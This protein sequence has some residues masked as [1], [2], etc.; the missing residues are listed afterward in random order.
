VADGA[1]ELTFS[2]GAILF[3]DAGPDGDTLRVT[4]EAW[5]DPFAEPLSSINVEYVRTHGK[6]ARHDVSTD[7]PF[8]DLIGRRLVDAAPMLGLTGRLYGLLLNFG[9]PQL[10]LYNP[11]DELRVVLLT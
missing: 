5:T 4:A 3:C 11:G 10:A 1:L 9:G 7:E 8:A 6:W 2:S